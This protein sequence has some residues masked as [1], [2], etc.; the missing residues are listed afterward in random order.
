MK[1]LNVYFMNNI[2]RLLM[3]LFFPQYMRFPTNMI[4]M[5]SNDS[6]VVQ[7]TVCKSILTLLYK[8]KIPET[9]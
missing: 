7:W 8:L 3:P 5:G 4:L 6:I 1:W 9:G 2:D